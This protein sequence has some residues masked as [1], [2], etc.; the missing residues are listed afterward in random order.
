MK[1]Y[2]LALILYSETETWREIKIPKN[3]NFKQLHS[4]IQKLFGFENYHDWQ[5]KVP[6]EIEGGEAIDLTNIIK[7]VSSEESKISIDDI[8]DEYDVLVYE[9]DFGDSWEIIVNKK[10]EIE[11]KYKT[12]LIT[13]Y[14]GKY[15]PMDDLGG[16][17]IFDEIIE[18]INDKEELDYVLDEYNLSRGDLSKMDFEKKYKKG[19]RIKINK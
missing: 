15:N 5:F 6:A 3:I 11:Y 2:E 10:S 14:C 17:M 12:A 7:T 13:D 1:G 4:V 16:F 9:Y 8:F 19:S 18:S